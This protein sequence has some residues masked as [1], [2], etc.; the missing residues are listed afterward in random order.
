MK[1]LTIIFLLLLS[2][3]SCTHNNGDIGPLFGTWKLTS[4]NING[5]PDK[6]YKENS[7]M[8]FQ[9]DA[10]GVNTPDTNEGYWEIGK[11]TM[12]GK[13][14]TI[15]YDNNVFNAPEYLHINKGVNVFSVT[16]L[17]G[18]SLIFSRMLGGKI[19]TYNLVKWD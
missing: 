6:N 1:Q 18:K 12:E 2:L 7:F 11:W 3:T 5:V 4:I 14:L 8:A 13:E 17:T 16:E 19:Y 9:N 10:I 15:T